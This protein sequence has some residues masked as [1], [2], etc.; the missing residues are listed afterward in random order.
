[1]TVLESH[2]Q[3]RR[4]RLARAYQ[5]LQGLC[6]GDAFGERFFIPEER[7]RSLIDQK[8]ATRTT[9]DF[10]RRHDDGNLHCFHA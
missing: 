2:A 3:N 1:M 10:H 9:V 8:S 7:A 6:C 4:D 5:S